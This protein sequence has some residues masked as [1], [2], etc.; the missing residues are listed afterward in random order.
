MR[1]ITF[2]FS[3]ARRESTEREEPIA[4]PTCEISRDF[5]AAQIS[6]PISFLKKNLFCSFVGCLCWGSFTQYKPLRQYSYF[7][8]HL[9]FLS[10]KGVYQI[11]H[12]Y[13]VTI[14]PTCP[15]VVGRCG[16]AWRTLPS[17]RQQTRL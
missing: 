11:P 8:C 6:Y 10:N 4:F 9:E 5:R 7:H 16:S 3:M 13:A 2:Y 17:Q 14:P 15:P 12:N 1:F